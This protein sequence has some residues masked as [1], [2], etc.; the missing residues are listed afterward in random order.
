MNIFNIIN[1][2]SIITYNKIINKTSKPSFFILSVDQSLEILLKH[3]ELATISEPFAL[4]FIISVPL[5]N[6]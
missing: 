3:N 1:C 4:N 5:T 2:N 6:K